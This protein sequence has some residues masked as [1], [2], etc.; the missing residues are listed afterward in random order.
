LPPSEKRERG[1]IT[2][3]LQHMKR[4][5]R[6]ELTSTAVILFVGTAKTGR[7]RS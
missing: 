3:L 4:L 6:S 2:H 7:K 1:L 5:R